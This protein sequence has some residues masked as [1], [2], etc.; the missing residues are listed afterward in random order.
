MLRDQR[1]RLLRR[2]FRASLPT[3]GPIGPMARRRSAASGGGGRSV[4]PRLMA[5]A[6]VR[7]A[8]LRLLPLRRGRTMVLL[9]SGVLPAEVLAGRG[10][11]A[12]DRPGSSATGA[13]VLPADGA[14]GRVGLLACGATGMMGLHGSGA[15]EGKTGVGAAVEVGV[16]RGRGLR[17]A[18]GR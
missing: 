5:G 7:S 18:W 10:A 11:M 13:A 17:R 15:A 4:L 6:A 14:M 9:G 8:L 3:A 1:R 12:A 2:L 16:R